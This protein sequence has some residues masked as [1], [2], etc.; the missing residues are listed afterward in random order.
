MQ[1]HPGWRGKSS[2]K[3]ENM[4]WRVKINFAVVYMNIFIYM[5]VRREESHRT[6]TNCKMNAEN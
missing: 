4:K 2:E 3:D 5:H 1:N 6:D